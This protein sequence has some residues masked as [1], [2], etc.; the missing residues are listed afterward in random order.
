MKLYKLKI[1]SCRTCPDSE[2]NGSLWHCPH[3]KY[4]TDTPE[5]F[6]PGCPL[7][8]WPLNKVDSTKVQCPECQ[9]NKEDNMNFC[10]NCGR[11]IWDLE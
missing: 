10:A 3:S 9:Q 7:E 6:L 4:Y 2:L 5:K 1:T 8:L 11:Q